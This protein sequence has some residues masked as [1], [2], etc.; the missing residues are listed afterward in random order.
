ME[1]TRNSKYKKNL[2]CSFCSGIFFY[3]FLFVRME[4]APF[5]INDKEENKKGE[6]CNKM[7]H[8]LLLLRGFKKH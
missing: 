8:F 3:R 2:I 6:V 1:Q 7:I 4:S 5:L